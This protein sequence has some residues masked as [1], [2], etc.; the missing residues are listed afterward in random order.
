MISVELACGLVSN[1]CVSDD[2]ARVKIPASAFLHFFPQLFTSSGH[3]P[4][5]ST[6]AFY[7]ISAQI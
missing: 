7:I 6:K 5:M 2:A 1:L 4:P 3:T